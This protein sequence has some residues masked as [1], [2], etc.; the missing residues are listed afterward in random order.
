MIRTIILMIILLSFCGKSFSQQGF[1]TEKKDSSNVYHFALI[2]YC[3]YLDK[4]K[5]ETRLIYVENNFLI[6]GNLPNKIKDHVIKYL[7]K[8]ELKSHLMKHDKITLIRIVP[9]RVKGNDIF[10]NVIPFN[11]TYKKRNFKYVNGG[12]LGIKFE[13]DFKTNGLIF[14]SSEYGGI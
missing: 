14:K 6:T 11:V 1:N 10:V 8:G 3:D 2:K 13:F 5:N 7:D 9:L 12:G 4:I